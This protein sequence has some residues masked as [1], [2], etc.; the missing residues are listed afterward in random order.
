M[1]DDCYETP[2]N[3]ITFSRAVTATTTFDTSELSAFCW[4][5]DNVSVKFGLAKTTHTVILI[6]CVIFLGDYHAARVHAAET[7][8]RSD[9]DFAS[10]TVFYTMGSFLS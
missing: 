5:R 7:A 8:S 1:N 9:N 4:F 2:T 3:G 6:P 10:I